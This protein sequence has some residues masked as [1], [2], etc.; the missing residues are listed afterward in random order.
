MLDPNDR[1][2]VRAA[3]ELHSRL[4]GHSPI[5]RLGFLFMTRFFYSQ[6]VKDGLIQCLLYRHGG[7]YVGFLSITE[8]PFSFMEEGRRL[9]LVRLALI[10]ALAVLARPGRLRI[11]V[12]TIT[13][14]RRD[15]PADAAGIGEFLSFGVLDEFAGHRDDDC[16][17]R[18][19]TL[20]FDEG[21]RHFRDRGFRRIEWNVDKDNLRAMLLYRSYGASFERSPLAWPSDYRVRLEL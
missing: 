7:R 15:A 4:L 1:D 17:L 14:G 10:L 2:Q 12:D 6:L 20:L 11:L 19:P 3:A 13:A 16:R 18:I 8:K 21:I 5:P 9:H